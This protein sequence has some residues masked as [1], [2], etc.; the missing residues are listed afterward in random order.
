MFDTIRNL[1]QKGEPKMKRVTKNV[2]ATKIIEVYEKDH[3]RLK[4]LAAKKGM[5]LRSYMHYLADKEEG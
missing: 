4:K 2:I 1:N 5:S 3:V